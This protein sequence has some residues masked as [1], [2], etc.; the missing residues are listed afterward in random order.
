MNHPCAIC[1]D[2]LTATEAAQGNTCCTCD[3][4]LHEQ[5]SMQDLAEAAEHEAAMEAV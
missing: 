4:M 5:W 1:E 3:L 2:I